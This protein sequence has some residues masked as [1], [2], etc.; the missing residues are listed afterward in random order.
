MKEFPNYEES[1]DNYNG[2]YAQFVDS[3]LVESETIGWDE[4]EEKYDEGFDSQTSDT[5][6]IVQVVREPQVDDL[7]EDIKQSCDSSDTLNKVLNVLNSLSDVTALLQEVRKLDQKVL[8]MGKVLRKH[9]LM[10]DEKEV[11]APRSIEGSN[12]FSST[13]LVSTASTPFPSSTSKTLIEKHESL[14]GDEW[15]IIGIGC[16]QI[17]FD[18]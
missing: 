4:I 14:C 1:Y 17:H 12:V 10:E 11:H 6:N 13:P 18:E 5:K 3:N 16:Y 8:T 15:I 7:N 2:D 9:G